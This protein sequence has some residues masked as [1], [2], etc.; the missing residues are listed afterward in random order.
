MDKVRNIILKEGDEL[1]LNEGVKSF[2]VEDLASK[3]S[4]SKKTIYQY[5]PTKEVLLKKIITF[6]LKSM[7]K[8]FD[9]IFKSE[10]NDPVAQFI[11][12]RDLHIKFSSKINFNKL[13]YLKTR[14][15]DIWGIIEKYIIERIETF[16]NI[17]LLAQKKGYLRDTIDPIISAKLFENILSICTQPEFMLK[18]D[19]TMQNII[20]HLEEILGFGFFNKNAQKKLKMYQSKIGG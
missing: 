1:I 14:Y 4:M 20:Y 8:E 15:P 7:S 19:F 12:V 13:N 9:K 3:L 18:N 6:K 10:P 5:F 17:F 2:T 11:K 16:T